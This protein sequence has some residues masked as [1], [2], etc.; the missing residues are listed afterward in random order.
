MAAAV[1]PDTVVDLVVALIVVVVGQP[2]FV[3]V[4]VGLEELAAFE[5]VVVVASFELALI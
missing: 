3:V 4:A 1:Y 5:S 2:S